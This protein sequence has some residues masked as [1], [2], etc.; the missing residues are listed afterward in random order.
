MP[1]G[2]HNI[3]EPASLRV[4]VLFGPNMSNFREAAALV[5]RH[6]GGCQ[7]R[8]GEEL[9]ATIGAILGDEARRRAMGDGGARLMEEN[10]GSTMLHLE[11]VEKLLILKSPS[12]S[13]RG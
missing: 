9:A 12:P 8:D 13:G 11:V 2:G 4:A 6:G 10:G 1:T 5:L 7:V 3:L